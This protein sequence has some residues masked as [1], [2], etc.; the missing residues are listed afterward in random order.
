MWVRFVFFLVGEYGEKTLRP[1]YHVALF[2]Y[3]PSNHVGVVEVRRSGKP[4][5]C[6]VCRSWGLGVVHIGFL[7]LAS[8]AY[9]AGYI[10]K[11]LTQK[12][13]PLLSGRKPEYAKMSLNP[14]IGAK[15]AENMA[16]ALSSRSGARFIAKSGDIPTEYKIGDKKFALGRYLSSKVRE[17]VGFHRWHKAPE[18]KSLKATLDYFDVDI[19]T[20][21][22]YKRAVS[23]D[24]AIGIDNYRKLKRSL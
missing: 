8:S 16:V 13:N 9:I 4:C 19:A 17:N 21:R 18:W 23:K 20:E 11:G 7:E 24:R 1:H 6:A 22:Q 10:L 14:G 2:G 12:G 5:G 15:G 3:V